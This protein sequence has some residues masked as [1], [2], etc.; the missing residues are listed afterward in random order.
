[1]F[2]TNSILTTN[3]KQRSKAL[4]RRAF[5]LI[6]V[7][8]VL[9][10]LAIIAILAYNFF[11]STMKS[12][13][14]T[15]TAV[16]VYNDLVAIS[17]AAELY[18]IDNGALP[19]GN[20]GQVEALILDGG[21][22]KSWPV[23]PSSGGDYF[24]ANAM[25]DMDGGAVADDVIYTNNFSDDVCVEFMSRYASGLGTLQSAQWDYEGNTDQY[26]G[27]VLGKGANVYGIKW[28]TADVDKCEIH[29]VMSYND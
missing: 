28:S 1:M 5:T 12:A 7:M 20:N 15:Q 4:N 23:S 16:K 21:Y 25:D 17:G 10:I 27:A 29:M 14:T 18:A 3:T 26:P 11:G 19:A 8:V 24:Y 2:A 6:E 9:S 13:T 22:L